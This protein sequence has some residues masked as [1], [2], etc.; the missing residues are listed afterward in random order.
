MKTISISDARN[1]L[2]AVIEEV[3]KTGD[4]VVVVRYGRP[5]VTIAPF[6]GTKSGRGQ[7]PLR[8]RSIRVADDFD[9]PVADLWEATATAEEHAAYGASSARRQA[10][11]G[12]PPKRRKKGF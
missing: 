12:R 10:S 11:A 8:G 3:V 5:T 6:L 9:E 7:Y 1:H 2:P 4:Q